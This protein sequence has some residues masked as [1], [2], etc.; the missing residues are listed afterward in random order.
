MQRAELRRQQHNAKYFTASSKLSILSP[1]KEAHLQAPIYAFS[2][3]MSSVCKV[4]LPF[5]L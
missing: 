1:L 5:G 4:R 3:Q 2:P